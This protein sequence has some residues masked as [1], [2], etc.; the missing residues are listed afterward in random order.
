MDSMDLASRLRRLRA[1]FDLKQADLANSLG[2]SPQAVSK[3]ERG[4]NFPDLP[5]IRKIAGL[6]DV[7]A[8][9]L[10]G[11]HEE[12][13][14][15]FEA[16]VFASGMNRFA[17][18]AKKLSAKELALLANGLFYSMTEAVL[19]QGGVPVKYTGDG[20]LC[21]FSGMNHRDRAIKAAI[22][23]DRIHADKGTVI[24]LHAGEIYFGLAGH[25]DYASRDIYGDTVNG[26]FLALADFSKR[27]KRGIGIS[28]EV[29]KGLKGR[30]ALD[31]TNGVYRIKGVT[32]AP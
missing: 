1:K 21:F 23:S 18:R 17:E 29:R 31:K 7:S 15:V 12:S 6:F 19:K 27:V 16:T 13:R 26:A 9:H 24:F 32:G 3:W 11:M 8:D 2:V 4:Q 20:F 14:E 10:L 5:Q 30:Y 28:A 25:P 22:A